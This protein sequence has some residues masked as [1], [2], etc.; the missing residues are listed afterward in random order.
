MR[1]HKYILELY[2]I[3]NRG[4]EKIAYQLIEEGYAYKNRKGKPCSVTRADIRR[5]GRGQKTKERPGYKQKN[6]DEIE[7]IED[8]AVFPKSL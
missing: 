5:V 4:L 2:A 7:F 8:R 6:V 1:G 3:D